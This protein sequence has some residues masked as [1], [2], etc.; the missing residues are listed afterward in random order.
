MHRR[1]RRAE[2][3]WGGRRRERAPMDVRSR[4]RKSSAA[5]AHRHEQAHAEVGP[6]ELGSGHGGVGERRTKP[7]A[8]LGQHPRGCLPPFPPPRS[9]PPYYHTASPPLLSPVTP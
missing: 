5:D 7:P 6:R 9:K 3:A 1:S 2:P 4:L 8:S